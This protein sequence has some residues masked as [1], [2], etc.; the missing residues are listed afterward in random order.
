MV[1]TNGNT[2]ELENVSEKGTP[3]E[4]QLRDVRHVEKGAADKYKPTEVV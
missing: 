2:L 1:S 3:F 4:V